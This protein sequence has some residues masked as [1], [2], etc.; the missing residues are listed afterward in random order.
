MSATWNLV[1]SNDTELFFFDADTVAKHGDTVTLWLKYV[2]NVKVPYEDGIYATSQKLD[3]SCASRT[4]SKF[5]ISTYDKEGK[6]I[7]SY[8]AP[9]NQETQKIDPGTVYDLVLKA[10]CSSDFPKSKSR[11]LYFPVEGNDIF[12]YTADY[13]KVEEESKIDLAP[14]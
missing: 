12:R 14:K 5:N 13:F 1:A 3:F 2:R 9:E 7:R 10:A 6:F 8:A 4:V 11:E